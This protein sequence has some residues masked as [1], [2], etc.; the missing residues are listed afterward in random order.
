M[1]ATISRWWESLEDLLVTET[2]SVGACLDN[3]GL[4]LA[5]VSKT[6]GRFQVRDVA[7]LT[8]FGGN[9]ED[10]APKL[11]EQVTAWGLTGCP[12]S[13]AVSSRLAFVRQVTLPKAAAENLAQVVAYELDRFVPMPASQVYYDFQIQNTTD[14]GLNLIIMALAKDRVAP[15]L[16]LLSEAGLRPVGLTLASLAAANAFAMLAAKRLPSSWLMLHVQEGATELTH[17]QGGIVKSYKQARSSAEQAFLPELEAGIDNLASQGISPPVL[18]IYGAGS[19]G[20]LV[21]AV[22]HYNLETIYPGQVGLEPTLSEAA[23]DGALPAAGAGVACLAKTLLRVNLLP[24]EER[25]KVIAD[26]FSTTKTLLMVLLGLLVIWGGSALIHQRVRLYQVNRE[27]ALLAP[28]TRQVERLLTESRSLA[29][30][31]AGMRRIG[32]SMDT[33]ELLKR[34]TELIPDN[35]SLFNLRLSKE[36]LEISGLSQSASELIPRLEKSGWLNKTEFASP[37]VTDASKLD[38]FKIQAKVKGLPATPGEAVPGAS[39]SGLAPH[40]GAGAGAGLPGHRQS[41]P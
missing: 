8:F 20:G 22:Q 38:H 35:T 11:Q 18:C 10:L 1:A 29:K 6:R 3:S 16:S 32:Q 24:H 36:S 2:D 5:Q 28:Q 7:L 23:Q 15:W 13:L 19:G 37:I 27:I 26:N 31:M 12:V 41:T 39:P 40:R 25:A 21:G 30:Q 33:L 4:T 34:L 14:S 17:I 9:P